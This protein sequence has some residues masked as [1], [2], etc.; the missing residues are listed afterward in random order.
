MCLGNRAESSAQYIN[1][2]LGALYENAIQCTAKHGTGLKPT[3]SAVEYSTCLYEFYGPGRHGRHQPSRYDLTFFATFGRPRLEFVCNHEVVL[4]LDIQKGHFNLDHAKTSPKHEL[5]EA[6]ENWTVAFR[7]TFNTHPIEKFHCSAI[8]N[9]EDYTLILHVL[10]MN[11]AVFVPEHSDL[12]GLTS[13]DERGYY[14][15]ERK[16]NALTYYLTKFYLPT[17]KRAGHH[18]LYSLPDF[19]NLASTTAHIDYSV[20]NKRTLTTDT[21]FG[22]SIVDINTFLRGLWLQAAAFIDEHGLSHDNVSKT[23]LAELRTS[24]D[25]IDGMHM[26]LFFG[27][28]YV[29]PLCKREVILYLDIQDIH[30]YLGGSFVGKPTHS[31][32]DWKIALIVDIIFEETDEGSSK[33]VKLDLSTARFCEHLSVFGDYYD[34]EMLV[35]IKTTLTRYITTYYISILETSETTV[36]YHRNRGIHVDILEFDSDGGEVEDDETTSAEDDFHVND[37]TCEDETSCGHTGGVRW[38][39]ITKRVITHTQT[40]DFD[41][42]TAVTQGSINTHFKELWEHARRRFKLSKTTKTWESTELEMETCLADFSFVHPNHGDEV[43]FASSMAPVKVQLVCS[44]G[45][46]RVIFYL[47]LVEGYLKTLGAG[48]SLQPG[49]QS[50]PFANW[51][52]AFEVDLKLV[53][54]TVDSVPDVI[55]RRLGSLQPSTIKQLVLDLSTAK[56]SLPLST[57]PGLLGGSDYRSIRS[58]REALVYYV[59]TCFFPTFKRAHHHVLYTVPILDQASSEQFYKF[60]SLKFQIVPFNYGYG[61]KYLEGLYGRHRSI[62]ERNTIVITGMFDGRP[63][64]GH[65]I[66]RDINWVSGLG[67]DIP[68]GT[69]CL[70]RKVFL[71]SRLLSLL[72]RVNSDTTI[73]PTFS[74]VNAGEWVLKLTTWGKHEMKKNYPCKWRDIKTNGDSLDFEWKNRD[75]WRYE[76]EGDFDGNGLYTVNCTTRNYLSI[77]TNRSSTS[78]ITVKGSMK[79]GLSY[80]GHGKDWKSEV[81]ASWTASIIFT[82]D[83]AGLRVH[84]SPSHIVPHFN[85]SHGTQVFPGHSTH[86]MAF[87]HL[88]EEFPATISFDGLVKDLKYGFEGAWAGLQISSHELKVGYPVF[89]R[90]GDLLLELDVRSLSENGAILNGGHSNGMNGHATGEHWFRTAVR[91]AGDAVQSVVSTPLVHSPSFSPSFSRVSS[92]SSTSEISVVS[93]QHTVT[94]E[95]SIEVHGEVE[96]YSETEDV[97]EEL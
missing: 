33:L 37:C 12:P 14:T 71:E 34:A 92:T 85:S 7:I 87:A 29:Q 65:A 9:S 83:K 32:R 62:F 63:L 8:G 73:V 51:R 70:S 45:S 58:R 49:T 75:E 30:V 50:Y 76:H 64:P 27:P 61:A 56:F 67:K 88:K 96:D 46:Y 69:V 90:R 84:L 26:H 79:L 3:M 22:V 57:I 53:D 24:T 95:S 89:N 74:G 17:I 78:I 19:D 55:L 41:F 18:V 72:E 77:P 81:T 52:L 48:K 38:G 6:I 10:D 60:T 97:E 1:T 2:Q 36:I 11:S 93:T 42:V 16:L 59:Q 40:A 35:R 25:G 31:L 68:F 20:I 86:A 82:S 39:I 5:H 21:L 13:A 28:L 47:H 66:P 91:K 15:R 4:F 43:F 44:E 54:A 80:D 23:S 94:K